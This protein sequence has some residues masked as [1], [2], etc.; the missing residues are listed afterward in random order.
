MSTSSNKEHKNAE[1]EKFGKY[2]VGP[3]AGF[4]SFLQVASENSF[5]S[6]AET[7]DSFESRSEK[8]QRSV[9]S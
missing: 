9:D 8:G 6:Q 1:E 7:F 3:G 5:L 2:A 4:L